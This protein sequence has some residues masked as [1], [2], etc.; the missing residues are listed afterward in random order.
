M[1][2]DKDLREI[3]E[4]YKKGYDISRF[5]DV[6]YE[7]FIVPKWKEEAVPVIGIEWELQ[8]ALLTEDCKGKKVDFSRTS[9]LPEDS[10]EIYYVPYHEYYDEY[11]YGDICNL[12]LSSK[13]KWLR[14]KAEFYVERFYVDMGNFEIVSVPV[15]LSEL[16]K[17]FE[18]VNKF[19]YNYFGELV[20]KGLYPFALFIPATDMREDSLVFKH[21]NVSFVSRRVLKNPAEYPVI[22]TWK[23]A[24]YEQY[25]DY[26]IS[27]LEIKVP[28]NFKLYKELVLGLKNSLLVIFYEYLS[29]GVDRSEKIG[30]ILEG[31]L[32]YNTDIVSFV[33]DKAQKYTSILVSAISDALEKNRMKYGKMTEPELLLYSKTGER[34]V[35]PGKLY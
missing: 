33:W 14:S 27:R 10:F 26:G 17:M 7:D 31:Y 1:L 6:V 5:K 22:Y 2:S 25:E 21:V 13:S 20:K 16:D 12:R 19:L 30:E 34:L 28:Y 9:E 24:E 4:V 18:G 11:S 23:L 29:V 15:P 8:A 3:L 35:M 32:H